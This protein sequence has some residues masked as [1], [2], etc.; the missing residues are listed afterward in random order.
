MSSQYGFSFDDFVETEDE[1]VEEYDPFF[2]P[3]L[4]PNAKKIV[5]PGDLFRHVQS[6]IQTGFATDT[7]P[8]TVS[9]PRG[10]LAWDFDK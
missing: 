1:M 10:K 2:V 4:A 3:S 7:T 9:V 8:G 6:P 5:R